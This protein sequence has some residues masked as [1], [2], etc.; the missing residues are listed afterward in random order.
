[1][2]GLRALSGVSVTVPRLTGSQTQCIRPLHQLATAALHSLSGPTLG[3]PRPSSW[4]GTAPCLRQRPQTTAAAAQG[5]S[6]TA[7]GGPASTAG[8]AGGQE[9][10]GA[11]PAAGAPAMRPGQGPGHE[12]AAPGAARGWGSDLLQPGLDDDGEPP[13]VEAGGPAAQEG[14]LLELQ[15]EEALPRRHVVTA[16]VQRGDGK[17]LLVQ[18]SEQVGSYPMMWGG[19]SGF[20]EPGDASLLGRALMEAEEELGL[21]AETLECVRSGR[22]LMVDDGPRRSFAVHPFLL[23]L[24]HEHL[25]VQLNWENV[26][27]QWV[28]PAEIAALETV[29]DLVATA[30]RVLPFP[31]QCGALQRLQD[32]RQHGAA[33]LAGW[34]LDALRAMVQERS[35]RIDPNAN[36]VHEL[37]AAAD[38]VYQLATCRP[39]MA[40]VA[41]AALRVMTTCDAD[42]L[43]RADA[44]D[45]TAQEVWDALTEATHVVQRQ[46]EEG[47]QG[48]VVHATSLLKDGDTVMTLS[49][50]STILRIFQ[51]AG[52]SGKHVRAIV[53]ESRPLCEGVAL[54]DRLSSMGIPTTVIT[55]AQAALFVR[56]ASCVL[57]GADA[58]S[59]SGGVVNK[60]GTHMVALAAASA[61]VAVYSVADTSKVWA[62]P[63]ASL[64]HPLPIIPPGAMCSGCGTAG[65][66]GA[67]GSGGGQVSPEPALGGLVAGVGAP[68]EDEGEE[69]EQ[70]EVTQGWP[71]QPEHRL[72]VRNVY[73]EGTP[74]D[75]F[76]AVVTER[77]VADGG[78]IAAVAEE[79]R[80]IVMQALRLKA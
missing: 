22:P 27:Y 24:T 69:K 8:T 66:G 56:R 7:Q 76:A 35:S 64:V 6:G 38:F 61:G 49:M 2:N 80:G 54:A 50:S 59:P 52:L 30:A 33:Q 55:D 39:A 9:P 71:V 20:L 63:T 28:E 48:A 57:V 21:P 5:R 14:R 53:C 13:P 11:A 10:V 12:S 78:A 46:L 51:M 44:F 58:V 68:A 32:D 42:L 26:G 45:R 77:G 60:V 70:V 37:D 29:P 31:Q 62:G 74:L 25:Q 75:L 36:G 16:F 3:S 4:A 19:V 23:H 79:Q 72:Q 40:P 34:G 73:F 17:V 18:R 1:M 43:S 67:N 65:A 47:A 15:Q 41:N